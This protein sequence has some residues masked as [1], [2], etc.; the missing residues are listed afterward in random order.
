MTTLRDRL[1]VDTAPSHERVDRAYSRLDLRRPDDLGT[2]LTAQRAVLAAIRVRPGA[3]A[4][5]A[6]EVALMMTDALDAD[7]GHLGAGPVMT[8]GAREVHGT[9]CLYILLGS[10]LGTRVLHR[11]WLEAGDPVV[12]GAGRYL[13]LAMPPGAWRNLCEDLARRPPGGPEADRTVGDAA[14]LFDLH[15]AAW[16]RLAAL[17]EGTV[18]V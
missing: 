18:H 15:L 17:P 11:R 2:F 12:A 1:R 3:H 5:E 7:L 10:S 14:A 9:A 13:G 8:L 4:E 6:R 16:D